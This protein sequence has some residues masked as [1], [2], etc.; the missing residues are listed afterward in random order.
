MTCKFN[1]HALLYFFDYFTETSSVTFHLNI[2]VGLACIIVFSITSFRLVDFRATFT[3]WAVFKFWKE[4][5]IV[6]LIF[7]ILRPSV[8][9]PTSASHSLFFFYEFPCCPSC[10]VLAVLM[11]PST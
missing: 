11:L 6:V 4:E 2:I 1:V 7:Y 8:T 10:T 5:P 3:A 9:T